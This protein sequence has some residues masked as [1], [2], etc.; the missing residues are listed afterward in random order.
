LDPSPELCHVNEENDKWRAE[1][2]RSS[3]PS[4]SCGRTA[5]TE[6]AGKSGSNENENPAR[7]GGGLTAAREL[8][9]QRNLHSPSEG[10]AVCNCDDQAI[11]LRLLEPNVVKDAFREM[12]S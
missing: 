4:S 5:K 11:G 10:Y 6:H 3:Q 2:G 8:D 7:G 12:N 1:E 9:D